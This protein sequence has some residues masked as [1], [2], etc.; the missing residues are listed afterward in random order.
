VAVLNRTQTPLRVPLRTPPDFG[1]SVIVTAILG[2]VVVLV[3]ACAATVPTRGPQGESHAPESTNT[4]I[5]FQA[6]AAQPST[7]LPQR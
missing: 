2:G 4:Y 5:E 7:I 3:I 6:P 1:L